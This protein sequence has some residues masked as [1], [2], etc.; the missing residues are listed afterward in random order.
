M[1][2]LNHLV[3]RDLHHRPNRNRILPILLSKKEKNPAPRDQLY[4][5]I[6]PAAKIYMD[7][8]VEIT[9]IDACTALCKTLLDTA[10]SIPNDTLFRGDL[11]KKR[12]LRPA[13]RMKLWCFVIFFH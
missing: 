8:G 1:I 11:F 13:T 7:D 2:C 4:G 12:Y 9:T 3:G 10:Q 6:L 5:K